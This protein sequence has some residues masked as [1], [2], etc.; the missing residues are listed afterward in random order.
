MD[1]VYESYESIV[2]YFTSQIT[3]LSNNEVESLLE[4]LI[5]KF[6]GLLE[7]VREGNER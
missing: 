1:K 7:L 6:E 4:Q 3:E 5:E 2:S